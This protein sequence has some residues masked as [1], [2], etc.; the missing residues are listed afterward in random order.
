D[1]IFIDVDLPSGF[2]YSRN[3]HRPTCKINW[4]EGNRKNREITATMLIL[5]FKPTRCNMMTNGNICSKRHKTHYEF[6]EH[7]PEYSPNDVHIS[8][9]CHH[10][11]CLNRNHLLFEPDVINSRR[12]V[13]RL[14]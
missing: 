2:S 3:G 12:N 14:N 13:C 10:S 8:H 9:L 11:E 5:Y 7:H 1:H 4:S 6:C